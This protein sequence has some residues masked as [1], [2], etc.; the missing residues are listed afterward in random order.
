MKTIKLIT[1]IM[2]LLFVVTS[3][4]QQTIDDRILRDPQPKDFAN[5]YWE[6]PYTLFDL[7]TDEPI[8]PD[9][10]D[11][12]KIY[13]IYYSSNENPQVF[14]DEFTIYSLQNH[15]YYKF[16]NRE[17]CQKWCDSKNDLMK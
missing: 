16:K 15:L 17:N 3:C 4:S 13:K 14:Y 9:F 10:E 1:T 6:A 11:R 12:R 5:V 7:L 2:V 8:F